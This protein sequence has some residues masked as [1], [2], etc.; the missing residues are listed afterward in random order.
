[1]IITQQ[2]A[3]PFRDYYGSLR[4]ERRENTESNTAGK[5]RKRREESPRGETKGSKG[6]QDEERRRIPM[7]WECFHL[8]RTA[9]KYAP[10]SG[11]YNWPE[12]VQL[13]KHDAAGSPSLWERFL[14]P[15]CCIPFRP[16]SFFPG[17]VSYF[18][19]FL[20][21]F[22]HF[23]LLHYHRCH[24]LV[25]VNITIAKIYRGNGWIIRK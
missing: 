23:R 11:F 1:M 22:L 24:R 2:T 14:T 20:F 5:E 3:T 25:T 9:N 13:R 4:A 19:A 8:R 21:C 17:P 12:G 18:L 10:V 15:S 7:L 6:V 16:F